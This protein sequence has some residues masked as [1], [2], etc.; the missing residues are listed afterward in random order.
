MVT[1]KYFGLNFFV[2]I[3]KQIEYD[4]IDSKITT[5]IHAGLCLTL[6]ILNQ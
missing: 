3:R 5:F 1:Y 4:D 2:P 6:G